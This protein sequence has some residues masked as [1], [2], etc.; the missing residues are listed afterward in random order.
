[1]NENEWMNQSQLIEKAAPFPDDRSKIEMCRA[2]RQKCNSIAFRWATEWEK[3]FLRTTRASPTL[4]GFSFNC[5]LGTRFF[6]LDTISRSAP[7]AFP[8]SS[9]SFCALWIARNLFLSIAIQ[10]IHDIIWRTSVG[11][12]A[13]GFER[14]SSKF[15]RK[16]LIDSLLL[17]KVLF[18]ARRRSETVFV[19]W[20]MGEV[21]S[22]WAWQK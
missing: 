15:Q 10:C 20:F 6:M 5:L 16:K 4:K 13:T 7:S 22:G 19:T 8:S 2:R 17:L 18:C 14:N 1:M 12:Y 9:D 3:Y 21:D 11:L